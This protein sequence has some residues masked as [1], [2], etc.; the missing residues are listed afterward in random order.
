VQGVEA[1]FESVRQLPLCQLAFQ[2]AS[3]ALLKTLRDD[4]N[5]S[6]ADR[7][8]SNSQENKSAKPRMHSYLS[9]LIDVKMLASERLKASSKCA[10]SPSLTDVDK[11]KVAEKV[12][13]DLLRRLHTS[14]RNSIT[15][16]DIRRVRS[17]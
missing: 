15:V 13:A 8:S 3:V 16:D 5:R 2:R 9:S 14:G 11:D 17:I 10:R 7:Y 12:L 6:S 1:T 4:D